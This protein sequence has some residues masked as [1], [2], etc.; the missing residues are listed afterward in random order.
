MM[1]VTHTH[2]LGIRAF[3]QVLRPTVETLMMK[4][5]SE[6]VVSWAAYFGSRGTDGSK[7]NLLHG[8]FEVHDGPHLAPDSADSIDP[9][10]I[11][12]LLSILVSNGCLE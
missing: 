5:P 3:P 9:F 4:V 10:S 8:S 7:R 6:S 12:H 2:L 1:C 11:Q